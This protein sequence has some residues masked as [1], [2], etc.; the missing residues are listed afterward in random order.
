MSGRNIVSR[1][2]PA[3]AEL[4]TLAKL[5]LFHGLSSQQLAELRG[6]LQVKRSPTR[7]E[8]ITAEHPGEIVY[9]ILE[10]TVKIYTGRPDGTE[11][12]LA[13]LGAGEI[14]GEMSLADSFERSASVV[15]LEPCTLLLM[16][17][18]TF[19]ASLKEMPTMAC[20][21]INIL[22]R[23]LRLSNARAEALAALDIHGRVAAQLLAFAKEY[24][25][26]TLNGDVLIPLRLTQSD[27]ASIIG[28]SRVR[29]NQALNFYKQRNYLSV[30]RANQITIHN[31]EALSRRCS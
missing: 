5:S 15:T 19:W 6:L 14:V 31:S 30:N 11:V 28:A 25:E 3:V 9:I 24:G 21:L 2:A 23:R 4:D 13:I 12:I 20:N 29:V 16:G 1:R 10:G 8:I 7:A 22:S 26:A 17:R 18:A 27:L